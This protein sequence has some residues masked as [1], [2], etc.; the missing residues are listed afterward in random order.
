MSHAFLYNNWNLSRTNCE[1]FFKKIL[2]GRVVFNKLLC[3][4]CAVHTMRKSFSFSRSG[5]WERPYGFCCSSNYFPLPVFS[6]C[7]GNWIIAFETWLT[8]ASIFSPSFNFKTWKPSIIAFIVGHKWMSENFRGECNTL[9]A[10][11]IYRYNVHLKMR[12]K[13]QTDVWLNN[14]TYGYH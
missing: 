7:A 5:K 10:C 2:F 1:I 11:T 8:A 13:P 6:T 4:L 9:K 3:K 14:R 12:E